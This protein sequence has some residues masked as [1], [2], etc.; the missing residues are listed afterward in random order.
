MAAV[1]GRIRR[2]ACVT[3][4]VFAVLVAPIALPIRLIRGQR[5]REPRKTELVVRHERA[6]TL[7]LSE[8]V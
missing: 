5:R 2:M 4:T 7:R 1:G 3:L 8:T 6:A